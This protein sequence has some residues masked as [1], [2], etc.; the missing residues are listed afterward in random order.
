MR[1]DMGER[2]RRRQDPGSLLVTQLAAI[3]GTE[4]A[5]NIRRE[6]PWASAIF[7]GTRHHIAVDLS[8]CMDLRRARSLAESLA[9]YEFDLIGHFVADLVIEQQTDVQFDLQ[10]LTISDPAAVPAVSAG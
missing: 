8:R 2:F 7:S 9:A 10:V 3:F 5:V 4:C 6:R 1:H